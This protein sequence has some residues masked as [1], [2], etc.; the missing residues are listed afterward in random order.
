MCSPNK[1]A[2]LSHV[3][4]SFTLCTLFSLFYNNAMRKIQLSKLRCKCGSHCWKRYHNDNLYTI[5]MWIFFWFFFSIFF[6]CRKWIGFQSENLLLNRIYRLNA[7]TNHTV[8]LQ[9]SLIKKQ[10][11][12][13]LSKK[14]NSVERL[15]STLKLQNRTNNNNTLKCTVSMLHRKSRFQHFATVVAAHEYRTN[16][17]SASINEVKWS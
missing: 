15:T 12:L 6:F 11:F 3:S 7:N 4:S 16:N 9:I 10:L 17:I 5:H 13:F 2:K 14:K 8:K 1:V